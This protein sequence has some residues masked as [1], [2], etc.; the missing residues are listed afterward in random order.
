MPLHKYAYGFVEN[1][2][3]K[4]DVNCG[5]MKNCIFVTVFHVFVS[6][7][8]K[9]FWWFCVLRNIS[10]PHVKLYIFVNNINICCVFLYLWFLNMKQKPYYFVIYVCFYVIHVFDRQIKHF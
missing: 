3:K 10:P 9:S 6:I 5:D 7:R 2:K 8:N 4:N 1:K